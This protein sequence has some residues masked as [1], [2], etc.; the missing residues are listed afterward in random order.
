MR[1]ILYG[2]NMIDMYEAVKRAKQCYQL[3]RDELSQKIFKARLA[4]ELEPSHQQM[5]QIVRLGEQQKWLDALDIPVILR[6]LK[7][8]PQK[9]D[10][11][12]NE[13]Y[14]TCFGFILSGKVH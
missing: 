14:R 11:V 7:Q 2:V 5:E 6:T 1:R 13:C 10:P 4:I 8:N 9:I 12:R 3:L